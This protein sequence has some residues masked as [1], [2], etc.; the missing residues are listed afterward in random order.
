MNF[1]NLGLNFI[2][3]MV[4]GIVL[5]AVIGSFLGSNGLFGIVGWDALGAAAVGALLYTTQRTNGHLLDR[6]VY[7]ES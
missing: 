3:I 5:A 6:W 1:I 7:R 4:L 2:V